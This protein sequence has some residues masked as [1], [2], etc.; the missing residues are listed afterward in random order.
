MISTMK[1]N[2]R[3]SHGRTS[4]EEEKVIMTRKQK[5]ESNEQDAKKSPKKSKIENEYGQPN[6]NPSTFPPNNNPLV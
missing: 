3:R 4:G 6:K 1:V 5:V 2:E